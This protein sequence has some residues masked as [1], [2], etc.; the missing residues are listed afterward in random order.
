MATA[1]TQSSFELARFQSLSA[2]DLVHYMEPV[3]GNKSIS[4]SIADLAQLSADLHNYDEY[5]L[6]YALELGS[7]RSPDMFA[8]LVPE[9][10]RHPS[11]SVRCAASRFLEHLPARFV[12]PNLIDSVRRALDSYPTSYRPKVE[13]FADI[14]P[15]LE[16]RLGQASA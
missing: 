3:L 14:L 8:P 15:K 2:G 7:D 12:T 10:L 16:K 9:F 11:G 6:V 1:T 13:F 4:V 5:H